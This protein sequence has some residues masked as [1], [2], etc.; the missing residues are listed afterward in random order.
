M[1]APNSRIPS[2]SSSS[3]PPHPLHP[4]TPS[5]PGVYVMGPWGQLIPKSNS[6]H[7]PGNTIFYS[8]FQTT[9]CYNSSGQLIASYQYNIPFQGQ[10]NTPL[11]GQPNTPLQGQPNTPLQ[12]QPNT[13]LQGLP[14]TPRQGLTNTPHPSSANSALNTG[15]V[16][17]PPHQAHDK[18][19]V[20]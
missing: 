10:P 8:L 11:Q 13:P 3:T 1:A 15:G 4:P 20:P 12:G 17:L 18:V 5:I 6:T 7:Y 16:V 9:N 19:R 2:T 14:N